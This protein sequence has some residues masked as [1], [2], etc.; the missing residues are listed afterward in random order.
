[1]APLRG[2]VPMAAV[3]GVAAVVAAGV[4]AAGVAVVVLLMA[5]LARCAGEGAVRTTVAVSLR[6]T[7][8]LRAV[9]ASCGVTPTVAAADAL[10]AGM[11]VWADAPTTAIAIKAPSD[12]DL[13]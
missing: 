1:M 5:S 3:F 9:D 13:M 2:A 8:C 12:I 10:V 6:G 4:V 11:G 7:A